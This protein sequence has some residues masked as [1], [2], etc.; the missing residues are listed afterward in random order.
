MKEKGKVFRSTHY[1]KFFLQKKIWSF[2]IAE[3]K[4]QSKPVKIK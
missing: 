3:E 1:V 4:L 2:C